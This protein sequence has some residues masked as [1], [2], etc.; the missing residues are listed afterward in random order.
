MTGSTSASDVRIASKITDRNL[1]MSVKEV[2]H[3]VFYIQ[4]Q[5]CHYGW[6]SGKKGQ[7]GI[8][9]YTARY[10]HR[11]GVFFISQVACSIQDNHNY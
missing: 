10:E 8:S 9:G 4:Q 2:S 1:P 11:G 3:Q 6:T 5:V 7:C